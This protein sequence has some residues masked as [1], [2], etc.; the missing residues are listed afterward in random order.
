[1]S[2]YSRFGIYYL[3][4]KGPIAEFGAQWLGWDIDLARICD[5]PEVA[6]IEDITMAPR[7][8]G[9]HGTL[10]PPFGLAESARR[11]ALEAAVEGIAERH[12]PIRL[13]GLEL[14]LIDRFL[15]LTPVGD[16]RALHDLAHAMVAGLDPLRATPAPADLAHR[17]AVGLT[18]AQETNLLRWG[19]PY[20]MDEFRFHMTL[21]D[22]LTGMQ[23][24]L[25]EAAIRERL[26]ELPRPFDMTE[27]AL[28]GERTD[29]MFQTLHRY[30]LTG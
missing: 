24:P 27:I 8:Y 13:L 11:E 21:T 4:P 5:R 9:F 16:A 10:M 30:A 17:R 3:P 25:A 7:R 29:G 1:M 12:S 22:R 18:I 14:S 28:V 26:P 15:A 19:Y 23:R 6:G 2:E 20:V